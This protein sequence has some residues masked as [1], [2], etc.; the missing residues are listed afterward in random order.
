MTYDAWQKELT[1][2]QAMDK[3]SVARVNPLN[4]D[5]AKAEQSKEKQ[6]GA[7]QTCPRWESLCT[8][9]GMRTDQLSPFEK[10]ALKMRHSPPSIYCSFKT[11][12][13]P[14]GRKAEMVAGKFSGWKVCTR[15]G[16]IVERE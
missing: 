15:F 11:G 8:W 6:R 5:V 2:V 16:G 10:S 4:P 1:L 7:F 9:I 12:T 3:D 14:S 13:S